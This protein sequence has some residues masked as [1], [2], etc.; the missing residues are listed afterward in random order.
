MSI[1]EEKVTYSILTPCLQPESVVQTE[2]HTHYSCKVWFS[3]ITSSL[4][5]PRSGMTLGCIQ[6]AFAG[7]AVAAICPRPQVSLAVHQI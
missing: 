6:K 1:L 5:D 2:C 7:L 3:Q 4:V